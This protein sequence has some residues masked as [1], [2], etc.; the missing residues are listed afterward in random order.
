MAALES[1]LEYISSEKLPQAPIQPLPTII[2][3]TIYNIEM[4]LKIIIIII[5]QVVSGLGISHERS[6][7]LYKY[8]NIKNLFN[9]H[10]NRI[11]KSQRFVITT[12]LRSQNL[13]KLF[14]RMSH[15]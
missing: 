1:S 11:Q 12:K 14:A 7:L 9:Q 4:N 13:R 15:H 5:L 6:S 8:N 2:I 10:Q 3:Y